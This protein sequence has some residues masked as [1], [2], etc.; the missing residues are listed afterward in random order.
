MSFEAAIASRLAL[1]QRTII[2]GAPPGCDALALAA[3]A[4]A[5]KHRLIMHIAVDDRRAATLG[6]ALAF[7]A[8]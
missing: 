5:A 3:V 6:D 2:A 8:P 1:P 7:F 4:R